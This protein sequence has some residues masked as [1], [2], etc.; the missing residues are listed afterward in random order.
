[1]ITASEAMARLTSSWVIAPTPRPM[2]RSDHFL[3]DVELEQGIFERL[4]RTGHVALD[5]EQQLFPLAGLERR[6]QVLQGDPRPPLR[7]HRAALPGLAPLGDLPGDP[8]VV[9]HQ[10]AV[11]GVG[12]R[13]ETE[14]L[15]RPGRRRLADRV[16][17]LV[18][19]GPDP[20]ERLAADDRVTDPERPALH[21]HGGDR[22]AALVQLGLDRDALSLLVGVGA[23]VQ[24]G[25]CGQHDRLEQVVDAGALAGRDVDEQVLAA[26]LLGHQPVLGELGPH[27][28]RVGALLVDLVDRH[29]DRH[30]GRLGVVERLGGLRLHAVVRRDHEHDQV[31]RL[32]AAGPHGGEGLVTRRVDEGDLPLL[33]VDLGV[34]LVRADVLGDAAR[35][36]GDHV[37]APD[38]VEQLGLAVVDVTHHGHHRRAG[39]QVALVALVLAELDVERLEQLPV[40]FLRGDHLDG[41][42]QLGAEQLERLV[43]HRLGRGHHLAQVEQH[44]D[45]RGRVHADLVGEV[46]QRRTARQPDDLAVPAR[47]RTPPIDGA[48]MLSNSW[49]RCFFDFRPRDGRPPGRPNAPWV[50]LRPRP[51][52]PGRA[53]PDA[54]RRRRRRGPPPRGRRRRPGRPPGPPRP[55]G[56]VPVPGPPRPPRPAWA[57]RAAKPPGPGRRRPAGA[58]CCSGWAGSAWARAARP[59]AVT[60]TA[61]AGP[62]GDARAAWPRR[63]GS[64]RPLP[65]GR[66]PGARQRPRRAGPVLRAGPAGRRAAPTPCRSRS[67]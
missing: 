18:E 16:A 48:C 45:Q 67:S 4:D 59:R 36:V 51:P 44:L 40:L 21:E 28:R 32:G 31:G 5:D 6:L 10:E 17:V 58:A 60:G 35:L 24:L 1:M 38:R 26:E 54:A 22:P 64:G 46:A 34:G 62:P 15:H 19:H 11:A 63:P 33:A 23:Q 66:C 61:G 43:V 13:G 39:H 2:T 27:P 42:V 37:R 47:D 9:H 3:A 29:H 30:A 56:R 50:P 55:P 20:A 53:A 12:H 49:R 8:V 7:E 14:Y 65:A 52:P 57:R 25:I 41:V